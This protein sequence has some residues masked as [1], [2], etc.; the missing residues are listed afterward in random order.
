MLFG[1]DNDKG[2]RFNTETFALEVIDAR[3]NP[4]Q[5]L[6]HDEKNKVLAQLLVE[7]QAP[8]ALGVI[9]KNPGD[10]FENSWYAPRKNGLE[11]TGRVNDVLRSSNTWTVS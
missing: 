2:I 4:D 9:Y 11:R 5:V 10:S 7:L 8:M 1:A 3:T 6:R